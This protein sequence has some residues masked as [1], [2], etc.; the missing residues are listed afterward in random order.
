MP[1][2][3]FKSVL[4]KK[5]AF[6]VGFILILL[7]LNIWLMVNIGQMTDKSQQITDEIND[8]KGKG[9][10]TS[11]IKGQLPEAERLKSDLAA[12]FPKREDLNQIAL[13]IKNEAKKV[14]VVAN[15]IYD[16]KDVSESDREVG[17][18]MFLEGEFS[19]VLDFTRFIENYRFIPD[20]KE[21]SGSEG[22]SRFKI[23]IN[24]KFYLR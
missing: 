10:A 2:Q 16:K 6:L 11:V 12:R 4:I 19:E 8:K 24:G 21:Y 18:Q 14:N 17:F 22:G 23:K 9:E 7:G 3:N 1:E 5:I 20:I 15:V 13:D